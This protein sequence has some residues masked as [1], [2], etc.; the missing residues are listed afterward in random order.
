LLFMAADEEV[1]IVPQPR[2]LQF[3]GRW[4]RFDGFSNLPDYMLF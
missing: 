3:T 4:F 2:Q 1:L